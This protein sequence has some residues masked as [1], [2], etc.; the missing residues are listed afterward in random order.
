MNVLL[1]GQ[2]RTLFLDE[3]EAPSNTRE[4]MLLISEGLSKLCIAILVPKGEKERK[5]KLSD[6]IYVYAIPFHGRPPRFWRGYKICSRICRE[7]K[8]DVI[9]TQDVFYTGLIG[10]LLKKS[11]NIPLNVQ[12]HSNYLDN[13]FWLKSSKTFRFMNILGKLI[14]KKAD[15]VRAVSN[16]IKETLIHKINVPEH[17]IEIFPV[18][19]DFNEFAAVSESNVKEG[20]YGAFSDIVLYVGALAKR[21]NL[22]VLLK[23]AKKV[24]QI[25]PKTLF[26]IIGDGPEK[27][28]LIEMATRSAIGNSVRFEGAV[29]RKN[30]PAYYQVCSLFVLPS[31]EDG[32]GRVVVEAS[33]N[34][35]P[36]IV[37]D[38]C[39]V[40]EI[41]DCVNCGFVFPADRYDVLAEK[42]DY[43]LGNQD[44][45]REMG[46]RGREFV[47]KNLNASVIVPKYIEMWK[48]TLEVAGK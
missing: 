13:D 43:L 46:E 33:A 47:S 15:S 41:V 2:D 8:I 26:L 6:K 38:A 27:A 31:K 19:I 48:K 35:K 37:S 44:I 17:R 12:L 18:F 16:L 25:H 24:I 39:G 22:E 34:R 9:S 20:K 4:R 45:A 23:A 21:K 36:V 3:K 14:V 5:I 29:P 30:L 1:I 40:K 10:Y 7:N 42:I 32:W 28:L 11:L